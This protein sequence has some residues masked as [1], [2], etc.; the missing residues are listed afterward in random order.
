MIVDGQTWKLKGSWNTPEDSRKYGYD[1]W[2]Q[3]KFDT[4]I[5][6]EYGCPQCWWNG[7]N[8]AEVAGGMY[9]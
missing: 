8:P 1:F 5:S 4:L 6:T 2:Y 9:M 3:Y 7:F